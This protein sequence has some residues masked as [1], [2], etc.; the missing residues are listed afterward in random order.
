MGKGEEKENKIKEAKETP[1]NAEYWRST[2]VP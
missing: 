2:D 1:C